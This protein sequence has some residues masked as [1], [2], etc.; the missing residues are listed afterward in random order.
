[1]RSNRFAALLVL[2]TLAGCKDGTLLPD[3]FGSIQGTVVDF[4]TGAPIPGAGVTTTP[5]TDATVTDANGAFSVPDALVGSYTITAN[6]SGYAANTAT[7]AVRDARTAQATVFLRASTDP[8]T[9]GTP[10]QEITAEVTNFFNRRI[11]TTRGD[12]NIV[13][14]D[15]RIRN[16]GSA[17]V[18]G[19]QVIFKIVTPAGAFFQ[20]VTRTTLAVG[21][22]A[23]GRV[24]KDTGGALATDVQV[25]DF[26]ITGQSRPA[27]GTARAQAAR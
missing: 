24:E 16:T 3:Q 13:V 5:A 8:G 22:S 10:T 2:L 6:R 17:T 25:E 19:Y 11:T 15:Y 20:D 9:G 23:V 18:S 4:A 21:Q 14:V 1:M 7:V 12:S 26:F 27:H